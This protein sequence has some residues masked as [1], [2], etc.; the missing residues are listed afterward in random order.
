MTMQTV[1]PQAKGWTWFPW[2][3][4]GSLAT[5]IAA[6]GALFYFARTTFPGVAA[7]KP[8][9]V[10]AAYNSVLAEAARQDALGWTLTITIDGGQVALRLL[11]HDG[12]RLDQFGV[13]GTIARPVGGDGP[14]AL[15][16]AAGADGVYRSA[17]TIPAPGQWD[18]KI[19]AR[20]GDAVAYSAARRL[21]AP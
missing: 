7:T 6:N 17:E 5:V 16:F 13:T 18:L 9:E 21:L 14:R 12:K 20:D 4:I 11:D 3:I 19:I 1:S 8:Y 10:G 15:R 2:A